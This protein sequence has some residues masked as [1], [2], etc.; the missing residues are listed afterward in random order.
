MYIPT[1]NSFFS[2]AGLMDIGLM[3]AG[4]KINQ[5]VDLDKRAVKCMQMNAH[6]FSHRIVWDDVKEMTVLDQPQSDIQVFTYPCK[7]YS[8]IGEIHGV[9]T[10]DELFLHALRNI[11][12]G[13][14]E[15]Y[16]VEN[17]PGMKQFRVVMEAMTMLPGYYV[18]IF[19]PMDAALWLPQRRERLILIG[20]KRP[21]NISAPSAASNIPTIKSIIEK[22]AIIRVNDTVI[23]RLNGEYRDKPI[24]VDPDDLNSIAPTCVAHY[25]KDMG[26]RLLKDLS[27]AHGVRPFTIREYARL[28]GIPDDYI[29]PDM[30]Y[31]YM[32]IGNGVAVPKARWV[33]EQAIKYFN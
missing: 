17:V 3:Q 12:I 32:L 30:N 25:A 14:P 2:G 28:Q 8:L 33:G 29:L 24:I 26:T 23:A 27:Y 10:G 7:K 18:N 31:S 19:C 21:F 5:S 4:V 1:A 13:Q 20:T 16:V 15:M 9:R 11:A 22:G 6:Y